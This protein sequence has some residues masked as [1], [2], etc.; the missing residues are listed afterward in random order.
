M[1]QGILSSFVNQFYVAHFQ[2]VIFTS[3]YKN[4]LNFHFFTKIEKATK[5]HFVAM[6]K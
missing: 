6:R 1:M 3:Q 5:K 2:G 4:V